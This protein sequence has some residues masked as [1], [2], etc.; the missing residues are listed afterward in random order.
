MADS[1]SGGI[2]AGGAAESQEARPDKMAMTVQSGMLRTLGI[3]L[4]TSLGKVLVEFVANAYDSDATKV[5]ISI[6]SE[7]IS[8]ER[9]RLRSE[10]KMMLTTS[11]SEAIAE[12]DA[13]QTQETAEMSGASH[14]RFDVLMQIL[15]D[16]VQVVIKDDGHGM[17]W[18]EVRDKF[19][20]VNRQRRKDEQGRE[21]KLTTD[22]GR[23]VMGRKGVGKLAG[24]G[25]ALTVEVRSKRKGDSYATV[26]RLTDETLNHST[27]ISDIEIPVTYAEWI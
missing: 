4:Y 24:F 20:P 21:T 17:T 7:R 11:E 25:A 8:E 1:I 16:D 6:P 12:S 22:K 23:H 18:Q 19:L 27:N 2:E 14:A 26:L 15:P 13:G 5:E 3:N 10:A 9:T